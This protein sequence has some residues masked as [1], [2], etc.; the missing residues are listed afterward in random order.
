LEEDFVVLPKLEVEG[1]P[2]EGFVFGLFEF[3]GFVDGAGAGV[4]LDDVF[5]FDTAGSCNAEPESAAGVLKAVGE[6][7]GAVF[8][9][10]WT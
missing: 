8:L 7:N 4:V 10:E 3:D 6:E 5:G 9:G 2:G 1:A